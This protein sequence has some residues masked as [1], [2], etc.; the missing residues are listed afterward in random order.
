M[1]R[2][3]DRLYVCGW[4]GKKA[5]PA[6]NWHELVKAG[7]ASAAGCERFQ[8][9]A[10]SAEGWSGEGLRLVT[11]Q[12]ASPKSDDRLAQQAQL[13]TLPDWARTPPPPEPIPPRPL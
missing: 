9:T 11:P 7:L 4:L 5:P 13:A 2:A 3:E 10:P 6:G 1:T 12:R 8:F